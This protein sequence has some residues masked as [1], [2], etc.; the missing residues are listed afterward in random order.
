MNY[1]RKPVRAV[2][3]AGEFCFLKPVE[4]EPW[5]V[6][7]RVRTSSVAQRRYLRRVA[8][9]LGIEIVASEDLETRGEVYSLPASSYYLPPVHLT[10]EELTALA[11]CLAVLEGRFAYA[12]PLRLALVSLMQGRPELLDETAAPPGGNPPGGKQTAAG[13]PA[14]V[15]VESLI[16]EARRRRAARADSQG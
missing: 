14:G 4:L 1:K 10:A 12:K 13:A 3:R 5:I 7:C 6:E 15:D 16:S 11:A 8:R 9:K 2:F